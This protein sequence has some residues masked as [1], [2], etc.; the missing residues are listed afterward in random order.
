MYFAA[1]VRFFL[2][3]HK[4]IWNQE[5][6]VETVRITAPRKEIHQYSDNL[7]KIEVTSRLGRL[8][9]LMDSRGWATK[10]V[11]YQ[12]NIVLPS[13]PV[14]DDRLISI[15]Q[16]PVDPTPSDIHASDDVMDEQNS[17]IA[18]YFDQM[19]QQNQQKSHDDAVAHMQDPNYNPYPDMQQRVVKPL[20]DNDNQVN[21]TD[22]NSD[23]S[24]PIVSPAPLV[25]APQIMNLVESGGDNL[26]VSTLAKE[27][28]RLN[29][30]EDGTEIDLS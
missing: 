3:P 13:G 1:I 18:Q 25:P 4:R 17:P 24:P 15:S 23:S 27:A 9:D 6:V 10:D 28:E 14:D 16:F 19:I 26:S 5:G 12:P 29:S 11:R 20:G 21:N 7:S 30:L 8:A 22:V 2:K